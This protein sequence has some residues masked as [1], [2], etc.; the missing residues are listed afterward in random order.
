MKTRLLLF[1]SCILFIQN[2]AEDAFS[3]Y[4]KRRGTAVDDNASTDTAVRAVS[5]VVDQSILNCSDNTKCHLEDL[6]NISQND[7][8]IKSLIV[9]EADIMT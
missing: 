8:S 2:C 1:I 6:Q 9:S 3:S 4:Q 7:H 5:L